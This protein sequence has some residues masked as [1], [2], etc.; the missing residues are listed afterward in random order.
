MT[1]LLSV[2][3]VLLAARRRRIVGG[4]LSFLQD[5]EAER[6]KPRGAGP[7]PDVVVVV[8]LGVFVA[9]IWAERRLHAPPALKLLHI[10]GSVRH[11]LWPTCGQPV[12]N[13]A[14]ASSC[15]LRPLTP[16][17]RAAAAY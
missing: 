16:L 11:N 14:A 17:P 15:R 13:S 1:E 9:A 4:G 12:A 8:D 10:P 7:A 2:G 3:C 6:T 5:L